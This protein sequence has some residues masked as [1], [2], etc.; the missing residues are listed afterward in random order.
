MKRQL[1][2]LR[3]LFRPA[4]PPPIASAETLRLVGLL[5]AH[6]VDHVLDVGANLGQYA[7]LLRQA[8]YTGKITSFEPIAETH[9][10][11][12]ATA[13]ADPAWT[14]APRMA[15]GARS[16]QVTMHVSN[17]SD[18]SSVMTIEATTLDAIPR[19]F[20]TATEDVPINRLDAVFDRFVDA[21]DTV[22]LKLDTQGSESAILEGAESVLP[23][24]AGLQIELSLFALYRGEA[25][26][27][28]ILRL[29]DE[30]GFGAYLFLPG[31][32]SRK[33]N[34]QLQM[35]GIFFRTPPSQPKA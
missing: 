8:G 3:R 21:T 29:V 4:P 12:T 17:R 22:F 2:R 16:G 30:H 20:E 32:F 34:R 35:D 5:A 33:L 23:R 13:A 9:R 6:G 10:S 19:A 26:Y 24:I 31:Y 1:R 25:T 18:M 11:L 14:V 28:D 27:L 7:Q 15:L